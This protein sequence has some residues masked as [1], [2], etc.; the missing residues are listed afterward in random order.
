VVGGNFDS[1]L[2]KLIV[3]GSTRAEAIERARRALD[4]LV[5]EGIATVLPFHRLV[6]RD[7]AFTSEP[8]TVHTRWIE[9]EW[10]GEVAPYQGTPATEPEPRETVVVE[11]GGKRLEVTLPAGLGAGSAGAR[12]APRRRGA[13][14]HATGALSGAGANGGAGANATDLARA[15]GDAL[16]SPMQGTIVKLLAADGDQ[17][18]EG[19]PIVVLE[20]MKMEQPLA[21]HKSGVVSGLTAAVGDVVSAGSTICQIT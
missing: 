9:T 21:A 20:A 15:G 2:A 11:V 13:S 19:D 16:T 14:R 5:V 17:V 8:F 18:S 6:V 1:L 3:T 10:S 12:P 7:P 4:E